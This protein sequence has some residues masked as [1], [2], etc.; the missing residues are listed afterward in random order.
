MEY[1]QLRRRGSAGQNSGAATVPVV[2]SME[3]SGADLAP[4]SSS[5]ECWLPSVYTGIPTRGVRRRRKRCCWERRL[6]DC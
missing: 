6:G 4:R 3:M 5:H 2:S 1:R